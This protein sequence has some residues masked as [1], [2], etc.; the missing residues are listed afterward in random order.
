VVKPFS[1]AGADISARMTK[2]ATAIQAGNRETLTAALKVAKAE[3]VKVIDADSGGD[4]RLSRMGRNGAKVGA[5]YDIVNSTGADV[6]GK[7][8]KTGPLHILANPT[9]PHQIP[10]QRARGRRRYVVIPGVGVRSSAQHPGTKGKNTWA[11][12][13]KQAEPH[14]KREVSKRTTNILKRAM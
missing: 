9:K 4:G 6:S 3:H 13:R 11:R 5:R 12:G 2:L 7:V 8:G 1:Q 14:V 10:R